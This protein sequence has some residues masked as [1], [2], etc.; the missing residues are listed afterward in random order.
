VGATGGIE[1]GARTKINGAQQTLAILIG[2]FLALVRTPRNPSASAML[3]PSAR[4]FSVG[5]LS[6][7]ALVAA[8]MI[9]VDQR[10]FDAQRL[11]PILVVETF[12]EITDFGK[13]GYFLFPLGIAFLALAFIATPA[14]GRMTNDVLVAIM[15][16]CGFLFV[17]IGLPGLTFTILKRIIGRVRPSHLGPFAYMPFS[18]RPEYASLPSGHSTTAFAAAVAMG[19][20]FP[21]LRVVM[22]VYAVIIAISRVA[23]SA[24]FT[25]DVIAGAF[26]GGFGAVLVRNWFAVRR[27]GFAVGPD[28]RIHALA[29]PSWER[30]KKV[31]GRIAMQ[32]LGHGPSK[33]GP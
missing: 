27:L 15:V 33:V 4:V 5:L 11:L 1:H 24:H 25:S 9:Y 23:I 29:G 31:A 13:S 16:R 17:A 2:C 3:W 12:D 28:Q 22:W 10:A 32:Y 8:A 19:A 26:V 7:V 14:L 20:L 30:V 21:R 18:W 6:A